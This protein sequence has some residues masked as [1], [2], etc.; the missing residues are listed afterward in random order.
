MARS[1]RFTVLFG[2][3]NGRS[4][5]KGQTTQYGS[6]A[7][8]QGQKSLLFWPPCLAIPIP[9]QSGWDISYGWYSVPLFLKFMFS[10]IPIGNADKIF[11]SYTISPL[12]KLLQLKITVC[13]TLQSQSY[14]V[15]KF[16][17]PLEFGFIW[18]LVNWQ[19]WEYVHFDLTSQQNW[20]SS[21]EV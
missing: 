20:N 17:V 11:I 14:P 13:F 3:M 12:N 9:P 19:I 1:L 4:P 16:N 18:L 2:L 5:S 15:P 21:V 7:P 6:C 8:P 10:P